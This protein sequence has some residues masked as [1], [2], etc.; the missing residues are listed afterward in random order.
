M[1][2]T[3][4]GD[5]AVNKTDTAMLSGSL[6]RSGERQTINKSNNCILRKVLGKKMNKEMWWSIRWCWRWGWLILDRMTPEKAYLNWD[7]PQLWDISFVHVFLRRGW[8]SSSATDWNRGMRYY[9]SLSEKNIHSLHVFPHSFINS[10][11]CW[12]PTMCQTLDSKK[13]TKMSKN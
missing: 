5:P 7:Q 11:T 4:S 9:P 8:D 2:Q 12:V 6:Y 1:C 3:F 13:E 10:N